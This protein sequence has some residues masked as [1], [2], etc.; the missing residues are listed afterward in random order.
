MI[1]DEVI[2]YSS[3]LGD[4]YSLVG[5]LRFPL[6]DYPAFSFHVTV[7][8]IDGELYLQYVWNSDFYRIT[9]EFEADLYANGLID[10]R[11]VN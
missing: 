10:S 11:R 8:P 2:P 7:V 4:R 5:Y 6:E 9:D 3:E 1:T